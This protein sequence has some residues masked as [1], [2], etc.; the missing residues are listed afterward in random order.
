MGQSIFNLHIIIREKNNILRF[1][2]SDDTDITIA[3]YN[4]QCI[5]RFLD[6][7][8]VKVSNTN[9]YFSVT[10][11]ILDPDTIEKYHQLS[12]RFCI[13]SKLKTVSK[14]SDKKTIF[15][16]NG[17]DC[18]LMIAGGTEY[19][20]LRLNLEE[21]TEIITQSSHDNIIH[22]DLPRYQL[23]EANESSQYE[24]LM[25]EVMST[26]SSNRKTLFLQN[27]WRKIVQ[28]TD[29][30]IIMRIKATENSE[31]WV[32]QIALD[33]NTQNNPKVI[34]LITFL[35]TN[36]QEKEL[37][38]AW[39][40]VTDQIYQVERTGGGNYGILPMEMII[41][42]N[43]KV[44]VDAKRY[45]RFRMNLNCSLVGLIWKDDNLII[46]ESTADGMFWTDESW[47]ICVVYDQLIDNSRL[48]LKF[49]NCSKTVRV[50]GKL[51][52][53]EEIDDNGI[54]NN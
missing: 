1:I 19:I 33:F 24:S 53:V 4:N 16:M 2:F 8:I 36:V 15:I 42:L 22:V 11:E 18:H 37:L 35:I 12:N 25:L 27:I 20:V 29:K 46:C 10:K 52:N 5:F 31:S 50:V 17:G 7:S 23:D 54:L 28:H 45:L 14:L 38:S 34:E 51:V 9:L 26:H 3:N 30:Q 21:N 13:F 39:T 6:G 40:L 48:D 32:F 43:D 49:N 44:L 47:L 41:A